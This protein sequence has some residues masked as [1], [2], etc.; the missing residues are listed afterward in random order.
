MNIKSDDIIV[1]IQCS[2]DETWFEGTLNGLTG[3]FPSNYVQII[4][5][6]LEIRNSQ[7]CESFSA[8]DE[9]SRNKVIKK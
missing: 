7:S 5:D 8:E 3:W 1:L 2:E 6:Q 9:K 4:E